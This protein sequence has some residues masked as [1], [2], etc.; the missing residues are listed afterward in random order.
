MRYLG[1]NFAY[2]GII[3]GRFTTSVEDEAAAKILLATGYVEFPAPASSKAHRWVYD[4]ALA[5]GGKWDA[6]FTALRHYMRDGKFSHSAV[7]APDDI[8]TGCIE[9]P[10]AP[11]N[12]DGELY[13]TTD[14]GKTWTLNLGVYKKRADAAVQSDALNRANVSFRPRSDFEA[15]YRAAAA[16]IGAATDRA[17][18]DAAVAAIVWPA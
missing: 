17:G 14:G 15:V 6:A 3:Y 12:N 9:C 18:V 10:T 8:P 16:A 4:A 5:D 2:N 1:K 11:P 7:L 13:D